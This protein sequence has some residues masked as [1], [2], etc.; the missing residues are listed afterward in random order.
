MHNR[1]IAVAVLVQA[2]PGSIGLIA[3]RARRFVVNAFAGQ[4][5]DFRRISALVSIESAL[6]I[7]GWYF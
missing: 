6:Q 7:G 3:L 1:K 5:I 2:A 4:R